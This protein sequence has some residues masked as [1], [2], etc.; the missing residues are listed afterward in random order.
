MC[1]AFYS[2]FQ[3]N[4][5]WWE[6]KRLGAWYSVSCEIALCSS[7][8]SCH[9]GWEGQA[10]VL[11]FV[12]HCLPLLNEASASLITWRTNQGDSSVCLDPSCFCDPPTLEGSACPGRSHRREGGRRQSQRWAEQKTLCG[13]PTPVL[14]G[15]LTLH[16]ESFR[17]CFLICQWG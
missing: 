11:F 10:R 7:V 8:V 16:M 2:G 3:G 6:I 15:G 17:A 13:V 12:T 5:G 14:P 4:W 9:S 1:S